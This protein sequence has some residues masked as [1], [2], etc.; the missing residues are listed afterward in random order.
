MPTNPVPARLLTDRITSFNADLTK[1]SPQTPDESLS[2]A[3]K[4]KLEP[5][6]R[7]CSRQN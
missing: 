3:Q 7:K 1:H 4:R 6:T 5:R 2:T